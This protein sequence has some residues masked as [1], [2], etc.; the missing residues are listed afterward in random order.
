MIIKATS[1]EDILAL[2]KS[3]IAQ[4]DLVHTVTLDVG[5][6][7]NKIVLNL[8]DEN[9]ITRIFNDEKWPKAVDDSLIASS[10]DDKNDRA[11]GIVFLFLNDD[12]LG[13][14]I[15]DFGCGDGNVSHHISEKGA[16]QSVGYDINKVDIWDSYK[17]APNLL[18]T[19]DFSQVT[20]SGPYDIIILYD[21]I[22]HS[23]DPFGLLNQI[24]SVL[25]P[26]G[27]VQVR[28]HPWCSRHG[29]HTYRSMNKAFSHL[30]LSPEAVIK[31]SDGKAPLQKIIHPRMTYQDWFTKCGFTVRSL[32][33]VSDKVED[34][35][36]QQPLRNQIIHLWK[37]SPMQDY[38]SGQVFPDFPMSQSFLDYVL[39][40]K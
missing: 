33:A 15:L 19:T 36:T 35:F 1:K 22:D 2:L 8:D 39:E 29:G 14:K 34:F 20:S 31:F 16:I 23:A 6:N 10:E 24:K 13:K 5:E 18:L 26:G 27:I 7:F 21:V 17:P 32:E 28:C 4:I 11:A 30:F 12:V 38:A 25:A 37:S 3:S 9:Q 40:I